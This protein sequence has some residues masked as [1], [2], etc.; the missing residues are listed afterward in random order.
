M[1]DFSRKNFLHLSEGQKQ[2][3]IITRSLI[4]NAEIM[5]FDEPDSALDF[6]NKHMVL[7]KIKEVISRNNKS[8]IITLHDP[9]FALRYCDNIIILNEGKI[10]TQFRKQEV[11]KDF[12]YKTFKHIYGSIDVL[13]HNNKYV[14]VR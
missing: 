6:T 2:M 5:L 13:Y 4:Q 10:F 9:N 12:L 14:I 8:G 1:E 11:D 7:S 3:I